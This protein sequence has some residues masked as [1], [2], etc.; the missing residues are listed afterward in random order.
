MTDPDRTPRRALVTASAAGSTTL[1]VLAGGPANIGDDGN[2]G[3]VY[4]HE[5]VVTA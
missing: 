1:Q 2:G 4:W 5:L 3:E